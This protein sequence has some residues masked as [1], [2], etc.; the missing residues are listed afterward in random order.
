M[1]IDYIDSSG[2]L[3]RCGRVWPDV[4][5]RTENDLDLLA[6]IYLPGTLVF[7]AGHLQEWQLAADGSW[8][9]KVALDPETAAAQAAAS[10]LRAASDAATAA[11]DASAAESFAATAAAQATAANTNTEGLRGWSLTKEADETVTIDYTAPTS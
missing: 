4:M 9:P 6:G 7:T 2:K 10:A 3:V 8:V 1:A 5:V 11:N